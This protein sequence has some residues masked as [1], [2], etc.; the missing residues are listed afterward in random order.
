M[1][2]PRSYNRRYGS[3]R[4]PWKLSMTISDVTTI[5]V[6]R[7]LT[8][9]ELDLIRWLLHHGLE[10]ATD[11]LPQV[12]QARVV[13]HCSCGCP[14]VDLSVQGVGPDRRSGMRLLS[15]WLW[16]TPEGLFGVVLFATADR[17]A[18][19]EAWSVD[20]LAIPRRWPSSNT[21]LVSYESHAATKNAETLATQS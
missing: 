16:P 1:G 20:G 17:L 21:E 8:T 4:G 10:G 11:F 7:E 2:E 12:D 3:D 14:S 15:D 18:C 19:L 5:P 6:D 9:E 13:G